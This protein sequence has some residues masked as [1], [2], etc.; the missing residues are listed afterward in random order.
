MTIGVYYQV[1][2]HP[3]GVWMMRIPRR[4][5]NPHLQTDYTEL[6]PTTIWWSFRGHEHGELDSRDLAHLRTGISRFLVSQSCLGYHIINVLLHAINA[7]LLFWVL[8]QRP[9][10][11]TGEASWWQ[12]CSPCT[13]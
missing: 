8:K 3:S 4:Q 6:R 13:P 2:S 1:R 12:R 7:V 5:R 11:A 9:P 10:G